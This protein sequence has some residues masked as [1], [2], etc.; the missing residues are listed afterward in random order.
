MS[1]RC[2]TVRLNIACVWVRR[3]SHYG[4]NDGEMMAM[5]M[6]MVIDTVAITASLPCRERRC[7]NGCHGDGDGS[8]RCYFACVQAKKQTMA[9]KGKKP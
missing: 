9:S 7:D 6:V 1:E 8:G 4:G 5:M 2:V 3:C